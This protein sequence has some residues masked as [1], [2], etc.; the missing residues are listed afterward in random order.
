MRTRAAELAPPGPH[1][2]PEYARRVFDRLWEQ[3]VVA[4]ARAGTRPLAVRTADMRAAMRADVAEDGT[5]AAAAWGVDLAAPIAV[6]NVMLALAGSRRPHVRAVA[7]RRALWIPAGAD[8]DTTG[9]D[10]SFATDVDRVVEATRRAMARAGAPAVTAKQVAAECTADSALAV[11]TC[12][13][14][15][16]VLS[17]VAK[18]T[19]ACGHGTRVSRRVQQIARVGRLRGS[20]A[21]SAPNPTPGAGTSHPGPDAILARARLF[22][23]TQGVLHAA[24]RLA[25]DTE[26][27]RIAGARCALIALGRLRQVVGDAS[28]LAADGARAL[29][30]LNAGDGHESRGLLERAVA[31]ARRARDT[32]REWER[33]RRDRPDAPESLA[34]DGPVLSAR[35]LQTLFAPYSRVAA[36]ATPAGTVV[37]YAASIRR[38]RNP[39]FT[40]RFDPD[41]ER[42][43][44][45]LFDAVDARLYMA[46]QWGGVRARTNA[47]VAESELGRLR[48]ERFVIAAT[49]SADALERRHAVA[50]L[51]FLAGPQGTG[52]L[53]HRAEADVDA[54]VRMTALWA[55]GFCGGADASELLADA[56]VH[57][58]DPR[59][60]KAA[61]QMC[62]LGT[63]RG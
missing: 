7:A 12:T 26:L 5:P 50:S 15:A 30:R 32:A 33:F 22:V 35:A 6:V 53:R 25:L 56:A 19:V 58:P 63:F 13:T 1:T 23:E 40:R 42:A 46:Q 11:A 44:E 41:P 3:R 59:V 49:K 36:K 14:V 52:V 4:A 55:Y 45:Y 29:H 47:C 21:Y 39:L 27:E 18:V 57:D 8:P 28:R 54:V 17:D 31:S 38:V 37:R 60:R 48:D 24:E 43:A 20:A 62:S 9:A 61:E 34:Q 51:A 2:W 10:E 16:R